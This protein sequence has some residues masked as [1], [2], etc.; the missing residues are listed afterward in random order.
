MKTVI[1]IAILFALPCLSQ[2]QTSGSKSNDC[3][4]SHWSTTGAACLYA[5]ELPASEEARLKQAGPSGVVH[6]M[7]GNWQALPVPNSPMLIPDSIYRKMIR[8]LPDSTI[9]RA[10]PDSVLRRLRQDFGR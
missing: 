1:S 10:I 7:P 6:R 5:P 8:V 4:L 9:K 3:P 2:A